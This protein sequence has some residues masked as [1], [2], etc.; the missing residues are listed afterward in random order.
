MP[1]ATPAPSIEDA[2]GDAV[3]SLPRLPESPPTRLIDYAPPQVRAE[4]AETGA[5]AQ[6]EL[7][8]ERVKLVEQGLVALQQS[9]AE[10]DRLRR[11]NGVLRIKISELEARI[12]AKESEEHIIE[13]RVRDCL[14]QRD[15]AVSEAGEL[16]GVLSS[17][18]A[19]LIGYYKPERHEQQTEEKGQP[20]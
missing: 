2:I 10:R 18:G 11:E 12:G 8:A 7:P 16:R 13:E 5:V 20:A 14:A 6:Q 15:G 19:I 17:L 9:H 3:R 1:K 4:F